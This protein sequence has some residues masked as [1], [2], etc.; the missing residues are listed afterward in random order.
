[1]SIWMSSHT[2]RLA[3]GLRKHVG[4]VVGAQD[5]DALVIVDASAQPA[6]RG[7][8]AQQVLGGARPPGSR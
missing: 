1:M 8:G 5:L 6:D 7:V 4:G 3:A 2:C